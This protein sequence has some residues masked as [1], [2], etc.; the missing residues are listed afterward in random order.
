MHRRFIPALA[1]LLLLPACA[2][3]DPVEPF[4]AQMDEVGIQGKPTATTQYAVVKVRNGISWV[5]ANNTV[6]P[7]WRY[8]G[9]DGWHLATITSEAERTL[10]L[11]VTSRLTPQHCWI[12]IWIDGVSGMQYVTGETWPGW[13]PWGFNQPDVII[14][15]AYVGI[16]TSDVTFWDHNDITALGCYV[17]ERNP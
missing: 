8:K 6:T 5:N 1:L 15:T 14:G 12:G 3:D 4:T 16:W 10:V 11:S 7:T 2:Q 9:K 13:A 17:I